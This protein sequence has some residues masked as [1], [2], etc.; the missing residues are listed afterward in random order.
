M[1][2]SQTAAHAVIIDSTRRHRVPVAQSQTPHDAGVPYN[3][4]YGT[5]HNQTRYSDGGH[6]NDS[7]CA[8]STIHG[9]SDFD[10]TQAYNYARTPAG[11]DFL[12][13]TDHNHQFNDAC[14]GCTAA[15]V[16]QRY[17]DGLTAAANATVN[18]SFVGIYGMEWG[19]ISNPDAGF[20]NE[21]HVG[22]FESPKLFGWEPSSTCTVGV[23]CYYEV[24]TASGSSA[25]RG[26]ARLRGVHRAP[27]SDIARVI[28]AREGA[29]GVPG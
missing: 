14:S 23:D 26:G 22:V 15:Q 19:Y 9:A 17:H 29:P 3:F 11:L 16:V 10:P 8:S 25:S 27:I 24:Y 1:G 5:L 7:G 18:G 20:P 12:G 6:P 2:M 28:R 4:Y 21:G 13:I